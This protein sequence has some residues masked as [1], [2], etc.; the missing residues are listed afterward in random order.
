MLARLAPA[1]SDEPI[2]DVIRRLVAT[3]YGS[4]KFR[5]ITY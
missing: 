2:S 5:T 3:T 1:I 4:N